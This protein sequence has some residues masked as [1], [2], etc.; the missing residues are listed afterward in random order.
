ME[1]VVEGVVEEI[2]AA[3][4]EFEIF[5]PP[6]PDTGGRAGVSPPATVCA[7]MRAGPLQIVLTQEAGSL[8][9]NFTHP[10][11]APFAKA[12]PSNSPVFGSMITFCPVTAKLMRP[13]VV[14]LV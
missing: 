1:G 14:P 2:T 9:S 4:K 10:P 13:V 3:V 6:A 11:F 12:Q 7:A 5:V 8:Q